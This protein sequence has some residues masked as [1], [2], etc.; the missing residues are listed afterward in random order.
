[1]P[2]S[3]NRMYDIVNLLVIFDTEL[4]TWSSFCVARAC[5]WGGGGGGGGV[6]TESCYVQGKGNVD[7][8]C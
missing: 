3:G 2:F 7:R 8:P 1:M 5:V 6:C 4:T